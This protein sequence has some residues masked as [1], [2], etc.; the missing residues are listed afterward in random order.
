[1]QY[2]HTHRNGVLFIRLSGDLM[3]DQNNIDVL[4]TANNAVEQKIYSCVVDLSGVRYMNS[5]GLGI[6]ITLMTK[7]RNKSG[8]LVLV[9]PSEQ[10]NKLLIITKLNSIFQVLKSEEEAEKFFENKISQ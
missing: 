1:M 5:S 8:E 10:I 7:F 2:E 3:G 9:N 4:N 6:L